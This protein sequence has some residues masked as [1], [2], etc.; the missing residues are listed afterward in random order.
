MSCHHAVLTTGWFICWACSS[1]HWAHSRS[2]NP[3]VYMC[4]C[5]GGLGTTTPAAMP[6]TLASTMPQPTALT[7][8]P[9]HIPWQPLSRTGAASVPKRTD[10]TKR[11]L[12]CM[13]LSCALSQSRCATPLKPG[14]MLRQP[15]SRQAYVYNTDVDGATCTVQPQAK[16]QNQHIFDS[17]TAWS[18]TMG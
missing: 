4:R 7:S 6:C 3:K 15:V 10:R 2:T 13:R 12:G 1:A 14:Q 8:R 18:H 17:M 5:Q 9:K 16:A 11:T